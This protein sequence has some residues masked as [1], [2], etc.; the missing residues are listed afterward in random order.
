MVYDIDRVKKKKK[1]MK[2]HVKEKQG[3]ELG[4]KAAEAAA[5]SK[6]SVAA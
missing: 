1:K 5:K 6:Q 2:K 3:V 4:C